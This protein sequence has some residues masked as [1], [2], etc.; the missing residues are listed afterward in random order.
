MFYF[1]R[2]KFQTNKIIIKSEAEYKPTSNTVLKRPVPDLNSF[3]D[4]QAAGYL[5]ELKSN[6]A[7]AAIKPGEQLVLGRS[8]SR[9]DICLADKSI[10]AQ[11]ATLQY[12]SGSHCF[13]LEDLDSSNGT[14]IKGQHPL[15]VGV[16]TTVG[17]DEIFYL[18]DKKNACYI[19]VADS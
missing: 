15:S 4:E 2:L 19:F 8:K 18:A 9:S 10:S 17:T 13:L 5:I 7:V 1:Y 12:H 6:K 11:H 14:W 16:K 3:E